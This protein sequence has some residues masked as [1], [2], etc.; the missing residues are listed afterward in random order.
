MSIARKI[1]VEGWRNRTLQSKMLHQ[2]LQDGA[3][4]YLGGFFYRLSRMNEGSANLSLRKKFGVRSFNMKKNSREWYFNLLII[5]FEGDFTI[6]EKTLSSQSLSTSSEHICSS[7]D[8][9]PSLIVL[10]PKINDTNSIIFFFC[11]LVRDFGSPLHLGAK[12]LIKFIKTLS[13][14]FSEEGF[15]IPKSN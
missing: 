7:N 15:D 3:H 11:C 12:W 2:S 9:K 6:N 5:L 1:W 4:K 13:W 8:A 10:I 14:S